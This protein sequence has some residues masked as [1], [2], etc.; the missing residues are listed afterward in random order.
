MFEIFFSH[1][2]T[3]IAEI[4]V[5]LSKLKVPRNKVPKK[6]AGFL[7]LTDRI[8]KSLVSARD[9]PERP[10]KDVDEYEKFLVSLGC[11][12]PNFL[13][14]WATNYEVMDVEFQTSH[15][16]SPRRG[17]RILVMFRLSWN[18]KT[19]HKQR[20]YLPAQA[21]ITLE[22]TLVEYYREDLLR[23]C[24]G[25]PALRKEM[26]DYFLSVTSPY[27]E[28][29]PNKPGLTRRIKAWEFPDKY[30]TPE[31]NNSTSGGRKYD[32]N[33]MKKEL[34]QANPPPKRKTKEVIAQS[35]IKGLLDNKYLWASV[36]GATP[37]V[38]ETL[39]YHCIATLSRVSHLMHMSFMVDE[40]LMSLDINRSLTLTLSDWSTESLS[41]VN[42]P[43][44]GPS[45]WSRWR[46]R[47]FRT[48]HTSS[49]TNM[50]NS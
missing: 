3:T 21:A 1:L 37:G 36:S 34:D 48:L 30:D 45:M 23:E 24:N 19:H 18:M 20:D 4:E 10:A 46:C 49:R 42:K 22:T 25:A 7:K 2:T 11:K 43:P 32:A 5:C 38:V 12:L 39:A 31:S 15:R 29:V 41:G 16:M 13:H 47:Y 44:K 26:W 9:A 8:S 28:D 17:E 40:L 27:H 35:K 33:M 14:N 6:V 50:R